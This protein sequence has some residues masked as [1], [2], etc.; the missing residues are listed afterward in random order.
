MRRPSTIAIMIMEA[1]AADAARADPVTF[2]DPVHK[3]GFT[4]DTQRWSTID[5]SDPNTVI[6]IAWKNVYD[7]PVGGCALQVFEAPFAKQIK[8]P[9]ADYREDVTKGILFEMHKDDPKAAILESKMQEVSGRDVIRLQRQGK[10][11]AQTLLVYTL[12]TFRGPDEI[13]FDCFTALHA[14]IGPKLV[15]AAE[16]EAILTSLIIE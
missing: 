16:F 7:R 8:G 10:I 11:G 13:R 2:R 4:Y 9:L 6:A 3:I 1:L 15:T 12:E 14:E 5:S